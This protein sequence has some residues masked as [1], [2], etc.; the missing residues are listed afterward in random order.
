[1][2]WWSTFFESTSGNVSDMAKTSGKRRSNSQQSKAASSAKSS[3]SSRVSGRSS[4]ST[5]QTILIGVLLPF[6]VLTLAMPLRTFAQQRADLAETR[7]NIVLMEQRVAELEAQKEKYS[8]P[9]YIEEQARIRL[10][11]V[12]P[13]ET[14]YRLMDP[15][16]GEQLVTNSDNEKH[17]PAGTWHS[18]LWQ[19]ISE[20]PKVT[21]ETSNPGRDQ[22]TNPSS[23]PTVPE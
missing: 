21:E 7:E 4:L 14:P 5:G 23:L 17:Q 12:K 8:D 19:S 11:L 2:M 1:M 6:L 16:L 15:A 18:M 3:L 20:L 22:A 10:G 9:A 13:G